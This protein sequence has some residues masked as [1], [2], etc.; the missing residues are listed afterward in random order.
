MQ[1]ALRF[2][3]PEFTLLP[4][5]WEKHIGR[6][7]SMIAA[8][9]EHKP[10]LLE[11]YPKERAKASGPWP[12]IR[13]WTNAA[14]CA[15]ALDAIDADPLLRYQAIAGC[16]G[17]DVCREFQEWESKLDLPDPEEWLMKAQLSRA[18]PAVPLDGQLA[19]PPRCDQIMAVLGAL[20]DRVKNHDLG[21]DGK[22]TERRW[23]AAVD[24]FAV[25]A[26]TSLELAIS[27]GAPLYACVPD[28][29]VL[30][31]APIDFTNQVLQVHR[32]LMA[33]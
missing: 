6:N 2:P 13:S 18:I 8:F 23:L 26:K 7:T 14:I 33:A 15:A 3:E 12:S 30:T 29:A 9:H 4:A 24:C 32:S 21:P 25:V 16:V 10:G 31:K 17:E 11:A 22:L 5:D 19:I 1:N 27:A 20:V 28:A